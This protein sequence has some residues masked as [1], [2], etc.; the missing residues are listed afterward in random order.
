ME[1]T[2]AA[3]ATAT[4]EAAI[5]IVRLSGSQA[6][7]IAQEVFRA[8]KTK[9]RVRLKS[10]RVYYGSIV[11]PAREEPLDE[12]L[13]TYM[14]GPRSYTREDVVEV[15]CHGGPMP[16]RRVLGVMLKA[17]AR[18]AQ[19]GEFTQRA[20]RHG[21]IDLAQAE[22]VCD[23]IRAQSDE[24][25]NLALQQL[26][27]TLSREITQ[28]RHQLLGSLATIEVSID[29]PDEDIDG[30][31]G[32]PLVDDLTRMRERLQALLARAGEGRIIREGIRT[33]IVGK[34]NVGK[35]SLLNALLGQERAIVTPIAGTTRDLIEETVVQGGVALVLTD[36]AGIHL[37]EDA[38]EQEGV[39]RARRA[40]ESSQLVLVVFDD[41]QG[42]T[43]EDK[44]LLSMI[45]S[46]RA[47]V[48]LN[49]SDL[50]IKKVDRDWLKAH[51]DN[52]PWL[53]I[54]ARTGE[55]L[56]ELQRLIAQL[57]LGRSY[58]SSARPLIASMRH[59]HCLERAHDSL[60]QALEALGREEVADIVSIDVREAIHALGE[61]T[62]DSLEADIVDRIFQDFC[63]GK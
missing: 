38:V 59:A 27:G 48:L 62:G 49:K 41:S 37:T 55:G 12:V 1:D 31:A 23:M 17:G 29:F 43:E 2:I 16:L 28:L 52:V 4:G 47:V 30:H 46:R 60:K 61:I 53:E 58:E 11:D 33:A 54:S 21:R 15:S 63:L 10:H 45:G 44:S 32:P 35:S 26:E 9:K 5:G 3:I 20:F 40:L 50:D 51:V 56:E 13:L 34:P 18:L 39:E 22:A 8:G 19:P 57:F 14:Q 36:T 7:P 25:A 24:A 6:R 42:L